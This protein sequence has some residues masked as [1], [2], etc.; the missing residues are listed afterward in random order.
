MNREIY[1]TE[2]FQEY[3]TPFD[4]SEEDGAFF[5]EWF[6]KNRGLR[7]MHEPGIE[8][9]E[10][11]LARLPDHHA[12]HVD[13]AQAYG[14]EGRLDDAERHV[15]RALEVGYPC[16]GLLHNALACVAYARGDLATVIAE[17]GEGV[18]VD[19]QHP[20]LLQ[21]H[22]A[23]QGWLDAGGPASGKPLR[24][25]ARHGFDLL[26]RTAQPSL[27]GPLPKDFDEWGPNAPPAPMT[28]I[29]PEELLSRVGGMRKLSVVA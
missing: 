17:L 15:R 14:R 18:R 12:A 9:C 25:E 27:P 19:P 24:L 3:M 5:A 7:T 11:I 13:L 22:L 1:F 26:E 2:K 8:E 16:P 29:R 23:L 6:A 20:V 28:P 10:A 21:N 4:A